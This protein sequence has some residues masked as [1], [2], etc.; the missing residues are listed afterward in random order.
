MGTVCISVPSPIKGARSGTPAPLIWVHGVGIAITRSRVRLRAFPLTRIYSSC[1]HA[2]F[3][4][5]KV[6]EMT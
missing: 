4:Q 2:C 5:A 3:R 1:S 6:S